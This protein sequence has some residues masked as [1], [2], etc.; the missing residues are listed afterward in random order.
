MDLI[1]CLL[2]FVKRCT[3]RYASEFVMPSPNYSN[4][5]LVELF[6]DHFYDDSVG[7]DIKKQVQKIN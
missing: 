6:V 4:R 2:N 3:S 5:A 1:K 7:F